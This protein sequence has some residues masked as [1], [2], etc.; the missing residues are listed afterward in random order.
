MT[1]EIVKQVAETLINSRVKRIDP[2][3]GGRN[4]HIFRVESGVDSFMLKF[5]R[6]DPNNSR[7]R[8]EAETS[9][10]N[11]FKENGWGC[12]PRI[13]AKDRENNCILMEWIDGSPVVD[14]GLKDIEAL[15]DFVKAV[16]EIAKQ[17]ERKYIRFATE[18]CLNGNEIVMQIK[19][20]LKRLEP[21]SKAHQGLQEV[22]QTDFIPIFKEIT[23]WSEKEYSR[24]GMA[25]HKDILPEQLTLSPV[26]IG[27]HNCLRADD[28]LYFL[29]FEFFGWDDPVKLVADTLQHPG[30][31]LGKKNNEHLASRLRPIFDKDRQF[32]IRLWCLYP[33]FGLKWC[34]IMLNPFLSGYQSR[35][36]N[37]LRI[38]KEQLQKVETKITHIKKTFKNSIF[39]Y[40]Q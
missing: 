18:A 28:K 1:F 32:S 20:R 6:T 4:S 40:E 29:D 7:D 23:Y 22:L 12:T 33:L 34:M 13:V 21:A 16:H 2:V 10:L 14:F 17:K 5:F 8:F 37:D 36:S 39:D 25:F 27:F 15:S 26:D 24:N 3:I 11:L 9:A 38:N 19:R 31:T 35:L 30:S